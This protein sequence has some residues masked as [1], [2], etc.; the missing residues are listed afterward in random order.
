MH[1]S[2]ERD[3]IVYGSEIIRKNYPYFDVLASE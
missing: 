3:Y 1:Q 2:Q